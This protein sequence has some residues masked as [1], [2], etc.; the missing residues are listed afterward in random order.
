MLLNVKEMQ[1][2]DIQRVLESTLLEFPL[3]EARLSVPAWLSA[4]DTEHWL[5][6]HVLEKVRSSGTTP[7]VMRESDVFDAAFDD[8][9]CAEPVR[10]GQI[11]PGEGRMCFSLTLKDGLFN[12]ILGEQCGTEI[13]GDAHLLTLM[14]ELVLA[15]SEYDQIADALT[16]VRHTGYGVVAPTMND[17]KLEEPEIVRQ[18]SQ[19]GVKLKAHAPSL[20]L[21]RVDIE[22]EGTP[23]VG[24]EEQSADLVRQMLDEFKTAPQKVW[25]TSFFGRSLD[26]MVREGLNNKL[27]RMPA[28]AQEK[29]QETLTRIVNEG[30]GGMICILL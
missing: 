5:V 7:R 20:H 6:Q 24:T 10:A 28:D 15:K 22:T 3:R 18:G 12:Q 8:S 19:F 4:L 27:L 1:V 30:E 26:S 21:I 14:K 13:R 2:E 23:V 29:V 17:L 11:F 25:E 9:Q 16:A